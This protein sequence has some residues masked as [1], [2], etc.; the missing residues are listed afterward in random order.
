MR[1]KNVVH[2]LLTEFNGIPKILGI[3]DSMGKA[4]EEKKK[5]NGIWSIILSKEVN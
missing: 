3:F 5:Y 1:D 4:I 2:V